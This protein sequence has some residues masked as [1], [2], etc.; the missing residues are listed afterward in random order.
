MVNQQQSFIDLLQ[1]QRQQQMASPQQ[2]QF[3]LLGLAGR[4][5]PF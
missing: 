4:G 3:G 2:T 5:L 1:H